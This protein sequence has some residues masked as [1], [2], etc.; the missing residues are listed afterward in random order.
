M[1]ATHNGNTIYSK[2]YQYKTGALNTNDFSFKE[3]ISI[4]PNPT[5]NYVNIKLKNYEKVSSIKL[6]TIGGKLVHTINRQDVSDIV[7][8]DTSNFGKGIY[9]LRVSFENNKTISSKL[10]LN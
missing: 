2:T 6:Y 3:Q 7:T 8:I 4:Y 5:S 10:I 9:L 1:V